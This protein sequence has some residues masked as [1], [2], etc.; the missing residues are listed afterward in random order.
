MKFAIVSKFLLSLF[1]VGSAS[2]V[3]AQTDAPRPWVSQPEIS[4]S[5]LETFWAIEAKSLPEDNPQ[6]KRLADFKG[7]PVLVNFWATWCAPCVREMPLLDSFA[8]ENPHLPVVGLALDSLK[9]MQKFESKVQVS[10]PLLQLDA[11]HLKLVKQLGNTKGGLPFSILFG[12]DGQV[13]AI[14]LGEL[15]KEQL[16]EVLSLL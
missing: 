2:L 7:K 15:H 5:A 16:Q 8:K 14:Y 10:Y 4:K 12:A 11:H 3:V 6:L 13:K 9:N 1:L